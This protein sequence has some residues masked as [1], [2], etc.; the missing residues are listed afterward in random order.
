L[1]VR[2]R[3]SPASSEEPAEPEE[4]V[5]FVYLVK[6][7]RYYEIGRSKARPRE[8]EFAIQLPEGVVTVH[9]ICADDLIS[10]EAYWHNL[11]KSGRTGNGW[12]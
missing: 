6:S 7:R 4:A 8:Y 10:I 11:T 3:E 5:G 1:I 9:A 12:I 2:V